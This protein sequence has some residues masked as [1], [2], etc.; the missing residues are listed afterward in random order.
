MVRVIREAGG[1]VAYVAA[2]DE[3][4][5]FRRKTNRDYWAQAT[6]LFLERYLV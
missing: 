6:A 5:G 4:H 3:G 1:M 2:E